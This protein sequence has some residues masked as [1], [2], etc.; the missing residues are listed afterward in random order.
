MKIAVLRPFRRGMSEATWDEQ[1]VNDLARPM[2]TT[3]TPREVFED[4]LPFVW[5]TLRMQ[6][7]AARDVEDVAQEVFVVIFRKLPEYQER[8]HLR[9]WIYRICLHAASTYRRRAQVRREILVNEIPE[10]PPTAPLGMDIERF[11][12][13]E[14]LMTLLSKLDEEKRTVFAL[15]VIEQIPITEVAEMVGCP[16]GTVYSRLAAAKKQLVAMLAKPSEEGT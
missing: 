15:H 13:S 7:V 2:T 12:A 5:R 10:P 8:G 3:T 4:H 9:A 6:N 16:Q 11:H 14:H 1:R